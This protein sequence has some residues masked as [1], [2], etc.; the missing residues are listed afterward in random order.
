MRGSKGGKQ[1][2]ASWLWEALV[3]VL[4]ALASFAIPCLG[5]HQQ[6]LPRI[7][8]QTDASHTFYARDP[9]FDHTNV[10]EQVSMTKLLL[11]S[12]SLPIIAHLAMQWLR[13]LPNATRHFTLSIIAASAMAIV[14]TNAI[15]VATGRF[16]PNFYS[17]CDWDKSVLWDGVTNLCRNR[18]GELEGRQSFPSGHSAGS[19]ATLFLLSLYMLGRAQ[20]SPYLQ[21]VNRSIT[22]WLASI[23]TL[24]A[25]WI[26]ITRFQDHWHH[27]DDI[28]GGAVIG[29]TA[30]Y[31]AYSY[32]FK[33]DPD[34][35]EEIPSGDAN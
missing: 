20:S 9:S 8:I 23:P 6:S 26:A 17:M 11:I 22:F 28:V 10:K 19:F 27:P 3:G 32:Y 18:G 29:G 5:V 14:A 7:A 30:A 2:E 16:R 13:P 1:Q 21:G 31:I 24:V 15:K 12:F 4:I 35:Y 33:R 34:A 25:T